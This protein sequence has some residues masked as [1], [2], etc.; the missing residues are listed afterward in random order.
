MPQSVSNQ[1]D[2]DELEGRLEHAICLMH[3]EVR[4]FT[5]SI[6]QHLVPVGFKLGLPDSPVI[7]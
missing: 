6:Q 7:S 5:T 3:I 4:T 2:G 1:P